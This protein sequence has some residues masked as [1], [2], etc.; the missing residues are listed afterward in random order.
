MENEL[1]NL[2]NSAVSLILEAKSKDEL[3]EKIKSLISKNI[4]I[5]IARISSTEDLTSYG[6]SSVNALAMV[7]ELE[8][9]LN[10]E[11]PATLLWDNDNIEEIVKFILTEVKV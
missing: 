10:C 6:L 1:L 5:P 9:W 7:G 8:D 2:K 11:L 3:E 4:N